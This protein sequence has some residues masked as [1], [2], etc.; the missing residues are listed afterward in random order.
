MKQ[1]ILLFIFCL[2]LAGTFSSCYEDKGH[3]DYDWVP[4]VTLK[5]GAGNFRDTVIR[6]G[7]RLTVEPDLKMLITSDDETSRD[8]VIFRPD[9]FLYKWTAYQRTIS[10]TPIVLATTRN[11]DTVINL[12]L[13]NEA[14]QIVYSVTEKASNVTWNFSFNLKI[15]SRY[16]NAWLFL[17]EDDDR[18]VDLVLYGNE[19][20]NPSEDPWVWEEHVLERSGFPYRGKGAKF[21]Y[22]DKDESRIYVGTGESAG[23]IGKNDL[24]WDDKKLVRFQ[25]ASTPAVD[26]TFENIVMA[27]SKHYIA[28]NG[29]IYP[30]P[31]TGIVMSAYN[32][33]PPAM[34]ASG[35]YETVKLAPFIGG[36]SARSLVFD[37][38][39]HRMLLYNGS[40][41]NPAMNATS[42]SGNERLLNHK[43]YFMSYFV[44]YYSYVVVIAK[45]LDDNKYYKYVY[46]NNK[47]ETKETTEIVN[48]ALL[49]EA[50]GTLDRTKQ[51]VCDY[52]KG[53][54][55]MVKGNKLYVLR[56]N[57]LQEVT[58]LDPDNKLGTAFTGFDPICLLTRYA[59]ISETKPYIM[60]ATYVDGIEKSG[61][62]YYLE[63]DPT[64]AWELTVRT[65]YKNMDR[66]K[67]I[68]RF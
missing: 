16:S 30:K 37:E 11:L 53:H 61:K 60:V 28:T 4:E 67:G 1:Y 13:Q 8:T 57:T 48:G 20:G 27:S 26:F 44:P 15:E 62:V 42:L 49:D 35:K 64:A 41:G 51:Y 12:S 33:L 22:Y 24:Q 32:I 21:V 55:Y 58:L 47:L 45:N 54:F 65:Y 14:W 63:P 66:V 31:K 17:T 29:D 50:E 25:M 9:D 68:S 19:L 10:T 40:T 36:N 52:Y 56:G 38:T 5:N 7:Q 34:N 23:W 3:Y 46:S 59:E 39:N 2:I 43:L 18:Q 6:R